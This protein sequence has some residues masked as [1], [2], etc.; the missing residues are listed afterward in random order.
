MICNN[1]L[2]YTKCSSVVTEFQKDQ[3]DFVQLHA[4]ILDERQAE[5]GQP[6]GLYSIC[7]WDEGRTKGTGNVTPSSYELSDVIK[8]GSL[9]G[10]S[11]TNIL[12]NQYFKQE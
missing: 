9:E 4:V 6:M 7:I 10:S 5:F 8:R 11:N 3:D 12:L 1:A 2:Y